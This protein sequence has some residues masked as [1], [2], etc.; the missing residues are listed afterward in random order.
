MG[1]M[2]VYQVMRYQVTFRKRYNAEGA[3][4]ENPSTL[5]NTADGVVIDAVKSE[6]IEPDNLHSQGV[7]DE[8]DD[9]LSLGSEVWE[10]EIADGR[11]DEF[12]DALKNSE[13]V[14][15]YLE[16]DEVA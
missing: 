14:M 5:V 7:M 1:K 9:F 6:E 4:S 13:M 16:L 15:E 10:Y 3:G 2:D 8:D 11:Q 12:I